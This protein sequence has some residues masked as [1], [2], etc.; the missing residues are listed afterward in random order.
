MKIRLLAE[1]SQD[2]QSGREFYRTKSTHA[3]DYFSDCLASDIES[4]RFFGGIHEKYRGYFRCRSK[5]F[6]FI[7]YYKMTET[8]VDIYA[9]I[10]GRQSPRTIAAILQRRIERPNTET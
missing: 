9:V 3:A 2:L 6:P 7:I 10:D 4:L 8:S 1:A 5:R